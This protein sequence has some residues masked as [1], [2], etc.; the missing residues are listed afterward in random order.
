MG[1]QRSWMA[2]LHCNWRTNVARRHQDINDSGIR[3]IG[4]QAG[5]QAGGRL[6]PGSSELATL[7]LRLH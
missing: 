1:M 4:K 2:E 3:L 6:T 5:K 7:L